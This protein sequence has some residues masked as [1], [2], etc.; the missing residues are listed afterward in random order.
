MS[1]VGIPKVG[2]HS[3]MAPR[4]VLRLGE[5]FEGKEGATGFDVTRNQLVDDLK[6]RAWKS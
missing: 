2:D 1:Q 3:A 5:S 4:S 6:V